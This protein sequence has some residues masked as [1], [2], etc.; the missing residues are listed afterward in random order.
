MV[1]KS[2][3]N[4]IRMNENRIIERTRKFVRTVKLSNETEIEI[5]RVFVFVRLHDRVDGF[6]TAIFVRFEFTTIENVFQLEFRK[7]FRTIDSLGAD[8]TEF[9]AVQKRTATR[10][11]TRIRIFPSS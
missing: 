3:P 2:S 1:Q 5:G 6:P 8:L 4:E 11:Q 7:I 10:F 9:Y